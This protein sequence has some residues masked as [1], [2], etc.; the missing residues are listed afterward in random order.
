MMLKT[1]AVHNGTPKLKDELEKIIY[2][3]LHHINQAQYFLMPKVKKLIEI[4]Q[5]YQLEEYLGIYRL[6]KHFNL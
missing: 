5:K 6:H 2:N 1:E 3:D 4:I